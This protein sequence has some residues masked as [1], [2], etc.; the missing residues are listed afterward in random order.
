MG[1]RVT[2]LEPLGKN[3]CPTIASRTELFPEDCDPMT[4][5]DGSVSAFDCPTCCRILRIS[6][7]FFVNTIIWSSFAACSP[8]LSSSSG[9]CAY[10]KAAPVAAA[11]APVFECFGEPPPEPPLPPSPEVDSPLS[12]ILRIHSGT[13]RFSLIPSFACSKPIQ[14]CPAMSLALPKRLEAV[15]VAESL[16]LRTASDA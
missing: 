10:P 6:I 16:A 3:S 7:I 13:S 5:I 1:L 14:V 2:M 15:E 9:D 8:D 4:T 12:R 11:A